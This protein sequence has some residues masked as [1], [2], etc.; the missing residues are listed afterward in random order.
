MTDGTDGSVLTTGGPVSGPPSI[1]PGR[2]GATLI[3]VGFLHNVAAWLVG[4]LVTIEAYLPGH[5]Y[6]WGGGILAV[7]VAVLATGLVQTLR[8]YRKLAEEKSRGYTTALGSAI[9]DPSLYY[10]D[11]TSLRVVSA[12]YEPRPG[13]RKKTPGEPGRSH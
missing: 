1:L 3:L 11:R 2:S 12:P 8:G 13:K 10:V 4:C 9:Q 5:W 7:V 6:Y